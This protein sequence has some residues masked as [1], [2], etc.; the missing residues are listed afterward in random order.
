MTTR[1]ISKVT[2]YWDTQDRSNEGWVYRAE[3]NHDT[4]CREAGCIDGVA[5][6]DIDNA[7]SEACHILDLDMTPDQFAREPKIDGG[8]AIWMAD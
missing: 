5:D 1:Q 4:D 6:D 7:I 8:Y 3:Y 2:I